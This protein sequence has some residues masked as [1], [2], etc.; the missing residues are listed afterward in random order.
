MSERLLL[1]THFIVE[2]LEGNLAPRRNPKHAVILDSESLIFASV[3]S[4]WEASIKF[5]LGKLPVKTGVIE[6]PRLLEA[7]DVPLLPIDSRHVLA[8]VE[9]LPRTRDPFDHLLLGVCFAENLRLLT[10]D[11]DLIVHPL[12]WQA[13]PE[14]KK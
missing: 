5:R 9:P 4:L 10:R 6:W 2:L 12:A 11:H 3:V 14:G 8:R 7:S 1:D 13:V